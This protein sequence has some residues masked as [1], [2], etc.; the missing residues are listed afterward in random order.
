M[1]YNFTDYTDTRFASMPH[2][3]F[4]LRRVVSS[5]DL[6]EM[7]HVNNVVYLRWVQEAAIAHQ[8]VATSAPQ[9]SAILPAS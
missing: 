7:R 3:P 6:D 9:N 8:A 4:E 5:E 1:S 2:A